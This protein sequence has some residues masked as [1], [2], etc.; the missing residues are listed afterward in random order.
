MTF[1]DILNTIFEFMLVGG[2]VWGIFSEQRLIAFERKIKAYF[3][4][5]SFKVVKSDRKAWN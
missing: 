3:R 1:T 4:R 2:L 5:K